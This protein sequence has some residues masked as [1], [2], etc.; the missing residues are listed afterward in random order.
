MKL[1]QEYIEAAKRLHQSAPSVDTHLDLAGELLFRKRNGEKNP[2]KDRYL[3]DFRAG[4]F[5][6]IVSSVYIQNHEL[7][8][9][10]LR[11]ALKQIAVL[12]EEIRKN[13]E[14][15]SVRTAEDLE[16]VLDEDRIGILLYMEGLDCIGTD[17]ELLRILWELG[18][19]GASL[20][21]S[22]NNSLAF[23]CC[24][25]S[26]HFPVSGGLSN[27]GIEAVREMERLGMFLDVSHLNDDGFRDIQTLASRP[28]LATHSNSRRILDNYRNL[29]D[30]QMKELAVRGGTVG[31]NGCS[32]LVSET[33]EEES[34]DENGLYCL[35]KLCSHAEHM[36]DVMGAEHVG[37]GFDFCD[38]YTAAEH[39]TAGHPHYDD[40]LLNHSQV[41]LL[42][43]A[44]L[45]RGMKEETA[46]GLMG[47]NFLRY[48]L[49]MLPKTP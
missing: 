42:T 43:A 27:A 3:D 44:L 11:L 26:E 18:V 41:P 37:Y 47:G 29:T 17:I 48:F 7:P 20:T 28:F 32:W 13:P 2:L 12:Q 45:Q 34:A 24:K 22:R 38:S 4:G 19:R 31:L 10:G 16:R 35:E 9:N 5:R 15:L 14:F 40:C 25:A 1:K 33:P 46:K 30:Q 23:G 6:L 21:W 8:G 36:I 49:E 39:R